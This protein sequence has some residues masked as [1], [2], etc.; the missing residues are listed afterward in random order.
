MLRL[1]FS[2]KI[3]AKTFALLDTKVIYSEPLYR[4]V[5]AS[6]SDRTFCCI[7]KNKFHKFKKPFLIITSLPELGLVQRFILVVQSKKVISTKK[8]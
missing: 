1:E 7:S 3:S 6:G 5:I 2:K 8:K 4:G